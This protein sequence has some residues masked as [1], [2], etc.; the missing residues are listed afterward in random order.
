MSK[1]PTNATPMIVFE[2]FEAFLQLVPVIWHTALRKRAGWLAI[3]L[4]RAPRAERE[5]SCLLVRR[6]KRLRN[7]EEKP[8]LIFVHAFCMHFLLQNGAIPANSAFGTW[9]ML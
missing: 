5:D 8:S 7:M 1:A 4:Q 3:F 2:W 9:P 6:G